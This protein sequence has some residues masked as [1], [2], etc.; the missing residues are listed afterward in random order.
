LSARETE[1]IVSNQLKEK[2][3]KN[4]KLLS[5]G[6]EAEEDEAEIETVNE[7][8][9]G[10]SK[11]SHDLTNDPK[12]SSVPAVKVNEGFSS[13]STSDGVVLDNVRKKFENAN[14]DKN[15]SVKVTK[16]ANEMFDKVE[17]D[18]SLNKRKDIQRQIK[19]LKR[20]LSRKKDKELNTSTEE[21]VEKEPEKEENS[22]L[23]QY[24]K[25]LEKIR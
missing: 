1:E 6:E 15:L 8:Y 12:L 7:A 19:E 3:K 2:V 14:A 17:N 16:T 9:K 13:S 24:H 11:S 20:E 10:Q 4:F 5:F 23:F 25:Q 21:V 18:E 22:V